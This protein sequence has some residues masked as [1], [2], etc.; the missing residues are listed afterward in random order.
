VI[1]TEHNHDLTLALQKLVRLDF[2]RSSGKTRG[3]V[4][5][6][7]GVNLPTPDDVFSPQAI[8]P[9][10]QT[11]SEH[12]EASSGDLGGDSGD[13]TTSSG[14]LEGNSGDLAGQR[15]GDGCLITPHLKA[16]VVD[17]LEVLNVTFRV[18]LEDLAAEPRIKRKLSQ[19]AMQKAI[20]TVCCDRYLTLNALA[21]LVQ[22]DRDALRKQHLN[23]MIKTQK[24]KLAF[25]A[26]P[27]HPQ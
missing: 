27:N 1:T 6:L 26:T 16:P 10:S 13:L 9:A 4:Y 14:D 23:G 20:L 11:S 22:R 5:T 19:E 15:N 12:L 17:D 3:T 21:Q 18:Q 8:V 24:L 25:P 2:L 7:Y